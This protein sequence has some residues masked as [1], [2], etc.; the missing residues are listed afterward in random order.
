MNEPRPL[1]PAPMRTNDTATILTGT[2]LWVVALVVLLIVG[3]SPEHRW[4]IWTC[5]A[6]IGLGA[7]GCFYIW[8]RDRHS[9]APDTRTSTDREEAAQ[10]S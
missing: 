1:Q 6:G 10:G 2:G 7:F 8:R 9:P 4:W 3:T 5:V